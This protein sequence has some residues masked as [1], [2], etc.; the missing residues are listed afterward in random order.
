MTDDANRVIRD[1]L[2]R[3]EREAR[4]GR[5]DLA[6]SLYR[7]VID[8]EPDNGPANNGLGIIAFGVGRPE[9]ALAFFTKA[10]Q[11]QPSSPHFHCNLGNVLRTLG[12]F[13]ECLASYARSIQL[14]PYFADAYNNLGSALAE[15][16]R[17]DQAVEC[18][19]KTIDLKP[20]FTDAH[21]NLGDTLRRAGRIAEAVAALRAAIA[22]APKFAEA[23]NALGNALADLRR[24][25][26][27]IECYQTAIALEPDHRDAP[28]NLGLALAALER[29]EDAVAWLR[30]AVAV[31]P[32]RAVTHS[33]LGNALK[34]SGRM[35]EAMVSYRTAIALDPGLAVAHSNLGRALDHVGAA[36]D[37]AIACYRTAL[38]LA[39]Q[40]PEIHVNLGLALL[41]AGEMEEGLN[42]YEW[43]WRKPE[44]QAFFNCFQ[45][46]MLSRDTDCRAK[47]VFV[48]GEQGV[49]DQIIWAAFIPMI[50]ATAGRC[51]VECR[52]K[53]VS[54]FAR[55]FPAA[56]VRPMDRSRYSTRTDFDFHI[57]MGSLAW[58]AG[59]RRAAEER[60]EPFL[61]PDPGRVAFWKSRLA[62]LGAGPFIGM[63]WTSGRVSSAHALN[64][65][66]IDEWGPVFATEGAVFVSL[67][68]GDFSKDVDEA[69]TR[70]GAVVHVFDDLDFFDDLDDVA[71]LVAALDV[72][73]SVTTAVGA[74]AAGVGTTLWRL[75]WRQS[76]AATA[77]FRL[78]GPFVSD[79]YR[80]TGETWDTAFSDIAGRL[81]EL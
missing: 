34:E 78:R 14:N 21:C 47:T 36:V 77:L 16:G 53:L 63:S 17:W 22:T 2:A 23:H 61:V 12:R 41:A 5:S 3:A 6:A 71:A 72:V 55:S 60:G 48:W 46:P 64:Y 68:Y 80:N 31:K 25:D 51:L 18:Y 11:G 57:P 38:A 49:G 30:R 13:D 42:E 79:F 32:D 33:D 52:P 45:R 19:R 35:E 28:Y 39:P 56:E 29:W 10:V 73:I 54:L 50:I 9:A 1:L 66:R 76:E 7:R 37:D 43:R 65:T 69:R 40:V 20:S 67:Q 58:L 4:A 44:G 15:L 59:P 70:F 81:R 24:W 75:T 62:E 26:E 27:A 74:I 8:A